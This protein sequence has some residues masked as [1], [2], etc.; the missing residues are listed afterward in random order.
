MAKLLADGDSIRIPTASSNPTAGGAG[1]A[2]F[3]SSSSA[4]RIYDGSAWGEV[5]FAALGTTSANPAS[6]AAAIK[7]ATPSAPSGTYYITWNGTTQQI[8][9][10]MTTNGGGWMLFASA[11]SS[12]NWGT[13]NTGSGASW[14]N[15][16][17][18]HGTY[19]AAGNIGD[20]WKSYNGV[21]V[22]RLMFVTG[23]GNYWIEI[24]ISDVYQSPN[25]TSHTVA[26]NATSGNTDAGC[27]GNSQVTVMHRAPQP[28]DPWI[29][30]GSSHAC[31]SNYMFWGENNQGSHASFKNSNGGIRVYV[32]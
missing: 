3:N 22:S 28:E 24:D 31:G 30:A 2:Y 10:D 29:N 13:L 27:S 7:T 19:S 26:A 6:S 18:N 17:Y 21:S 12:G 15:L 32:K 20:Y 1:H 25:G 11:P 23:N 16:N 8:Y 5:S 14:T 9:C 4:L